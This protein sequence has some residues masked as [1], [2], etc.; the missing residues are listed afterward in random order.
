MRALYFHSM[1]LL[2]TIIAANTS[3]TIYES[4]AAILFG[5]IAM[6]AAL[7]ANWRGGEG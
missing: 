1:A 6:G 7:G 4:A 2:V 5:G 3:Q